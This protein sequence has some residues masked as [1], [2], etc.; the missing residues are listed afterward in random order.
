MKVEALKVHQT[1]NNNAKEINWKISEYTKM[2][3]KKI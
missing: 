1:K 3:I 2:M